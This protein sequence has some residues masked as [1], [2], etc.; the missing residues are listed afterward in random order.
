[1]ELCSR[2]ALE[3][4]GISNLRPG[5]AE[6]TLAACEGKDVIVILPTGRGKSTCFQLFPFVYAEIHMASLPLVL[7]VS[8]LAALLQNQVFELQQKGISATYLGYTQKDKMMASRAKKG[9]FTFGWLFFPPFFFLILPHHP[10]T[11]VYFCPETFMK[12][13]WQQFVK[14]KR[15][16]IKLLVID[17]FHCLEFR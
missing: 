2:I 1:M 3:K 13:E 14:N 16:M 15:S 9:E 8:P 10:C 5:Q 7:V 12:P 4:F 6:A 11:I 17:E